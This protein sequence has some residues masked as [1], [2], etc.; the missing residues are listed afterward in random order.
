MYINDDSR[1]CD[2]DKY[3][4]GLNMDL[5]SSKNNILATKI[6]NQ[7][8]GKISK[9]DWEFKWNQVCNWIKQDQIQIALE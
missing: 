4:I 7:S 6:I 5:W 1:K 9:S 3:D 8:A 2:A